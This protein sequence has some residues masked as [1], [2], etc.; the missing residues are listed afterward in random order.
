MAKESIK[1]EI[2]TPNYDALPGHE[3]GKINQ[4]IKELQ[5]DEP[6]LDVPKTREILAN[7]MNSR[8]SSLTTTKSTR[9]ARGEN[10]TPP[11]QR[12]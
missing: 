11:Y 8:V 9:H 1:T 12:G 10:N 6:N 4:H 3:Q 2:K 7:F 5:K